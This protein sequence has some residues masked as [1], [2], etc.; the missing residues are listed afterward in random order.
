MQAHITMQPGSLYDARDV[1][2]LNETF[3]PRSTFIRD[4]VVLVA[5]VLVHAVLLQSDGP[6][7]MGMPQP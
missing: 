1:L 2:R 7:S 4:L 5:A 3:G 6:L